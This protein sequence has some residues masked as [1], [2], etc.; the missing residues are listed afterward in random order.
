MTGIG[1]VLHKAYCASYN[2]KPILVAKLHLH[3]A[4][5]SSIIT[6]EMGGRKGGMDGEGE[7]VR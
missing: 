7:G 2:T 1:F 3:Y 5:R 6:K 4:N